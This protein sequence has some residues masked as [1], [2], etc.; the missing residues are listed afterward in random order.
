[1]PSRIEA[2]LAACGGPIQTL[3]SGVSFVLAKKLYSILAYSMMKA[4]STDLLYT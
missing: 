2:V 1:M 4:M 3:Y